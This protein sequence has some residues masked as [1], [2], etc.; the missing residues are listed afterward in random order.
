MLL[1]PDAGRFQGF[2]LYRKIPPEFSIKQ[3]RSGRSV[4]DRESAKA[5]LVGRR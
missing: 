5:D 4:E 1:S 3:K 2:L